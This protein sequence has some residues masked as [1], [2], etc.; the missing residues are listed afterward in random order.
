MELI[1]WYIFYDTLGTLCGTLGMFNNIFMV[2]SGKKPLK[3]YEVSL[4]SWNS[5]WHIMIWKYLNVGYSFHRL[6]NISNKFQIIYIS[7]EN[8]SEVWY[9]FNYFFVCNFYFII[10]KS[11]FCRIKKKNSNNNKDNRKPK[12]SKV[13]ISLKFIYIFWKFPRNMLSLLTLV[14]PITK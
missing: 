2:L 1:F 5:F 11:S 3:F 13:W 12:I 4:A 6:R 8:T 10:A 7:V 14:F 9:F